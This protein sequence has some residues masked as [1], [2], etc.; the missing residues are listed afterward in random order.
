M[1]QRKLGE[2]L[3]DHRKVLR[4]IRQ[5]RRLWKHYT[6]SKYCA[7]DFREFEAYKK[8][9]E[10]VRKAEKKAKKDFEKKLAKNTKKKSKMFWTYM[11]Q[12]PPT[13]LLLAPWSG[14]RWSSLMTRRCA[15]Y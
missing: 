9:Q 7:R 5:K 10:D 6:S 2:S 14:T 13:E 11:K 8:V 15:R 4:M 12:K 3:I 1:Y